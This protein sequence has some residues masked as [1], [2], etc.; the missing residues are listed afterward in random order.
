[1]KKIFSIAKWEFLEKVKTKAFLISLIITPAIIILFSILP[2]LLA[3]DQSVSTKFIGVIDSSGK[4]FED[5][6]NEIAEFRLENLQPKYVVINLLEK[7]RSLSENL[8]AA[9]SAVLNNSFEGYLYISE[10]KNDS[11]RFEFR[12]KYS[13]DFQDQKRI[14]ET[15]NNVRINKRLRY[16]NIDSNLLSFINKKVR[17]ES[18][19][20]DNTGSSKD[21]DY[22]TTFYSSI[23]FILLLMMMI[24]YSGQ[25]LV[26]SLL[27]EKSN[28]LIEILISSC[29]SEELLTGKILGLSAL[30]LTQLL[31]W[32]LIGLGL[33][34]YA[35]I[36]LS[37]FVN[38]P[39][40][41]LYFILGFTFYTTLFVGI[42]SIVST[43][44]EAQ[45]MTSYLSLILIIP[46][47]IILPA[48]QNPESLL[49]K[50]LSYIPLTLP[51]VMILRINISD[52]SLIELCVTTCIMII[53]TLI[54]IKVSAKIF[55]VGI[56][57]YGKMPSLK[58]LKIWINEK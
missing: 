38:L 16:E 13:I 9:D 19:R 18:I 42:G 52:V 53:S 8:S 26:R 34:G 30:G 43:E 39:Q 12:S 37:V 21:L 32:S 29:S 10:I 23:V 51:S 24:I 4:F 14:E 20:I 48:M 6:K 11:I 40:I 27:E 2:G 54:T 15:I 58:E 17:L 46:V 41:I 22:I 47:I 35:V 56:L 25:L 44:Q 45:Q 57:S 55:R 7:S 3:Q 33:T 1:M 28:R 31:I 49:I 50:V 5:F 36:P